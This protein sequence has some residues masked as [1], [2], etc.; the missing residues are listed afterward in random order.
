MARRPEIIEYGPVKKHGVTMPAAVGALL[1]L[2]LHHW[3]QPHGDIIK[4]P[5]GTEVVMTKTFNGWLITDST[6]KAYTA[7]KVR[8]NA[9][10][11]D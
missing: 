4:V 2:V 7:T 6:G 3:W 1:A 11:H 5:N 9:D 8:V 10:H